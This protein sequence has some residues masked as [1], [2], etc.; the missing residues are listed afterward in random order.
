MPWIL[1]DLPKSWVLSSNLVV[2]SSGDQDLGRDE[3]DAGVFLIVSNSSASTNA[4]DP[5][6]CW[7]RF[8]S[9]LSRLDVDFDLHRLLWR[10]LL[11]TYCVRYF[12]RVL[13]QNLHK[14][15][16]SRAIEQFWLER[17][18][19]RTHLASRIPRYVTSC[20]MKPGFGRITLRRLFTSSNALS[21]VQLYSFMAYAITCS[22]N[23][24]TLSPYWDSNSLS[25]SLIMCEQYLQ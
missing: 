2:L 9:M 10:C 13:C 14:Y 18:G 11:S 25:P 21:S 4:S 1:R 8:A 3:S 24:K 19:C 22:N 5:T 15:Q 16:P 7:S 6:S 20:C 23:N 12:W 17:W